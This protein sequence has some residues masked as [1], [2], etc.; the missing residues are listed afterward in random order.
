MDVFCFHHLLAFCCLLIGFSDISTGVSFFGLL[1]FGS[2]PQHSSN[3]SQQGPWKT[4]YLSFCFGGALWRPRM[5]RPVF[6]FLVIPFFGFL[7]GFTLYYIIGDIWDISFS[8]SN[9]EPKLAKISLFCVIDIRLCLSLSWRQPGVWLI[10]HQIYYLI[11]LLFF[12]SFWLFNLLIISSHLTSG[13]ILFATYFLGE[14]WS[15][16][17]FCSAIFCRHFMLKFITMARG[18]VIKIT[19]AFLLEDLLTKIFFLGGRN[20][21]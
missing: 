10:R 3:F 7:F 9:F 13:N 17:K 8:P 16:Y 15:F 1:L 18:A 4:R 5:R 12:N 21:I 20:L 14:K 2:N 6:G 19:F 11:S